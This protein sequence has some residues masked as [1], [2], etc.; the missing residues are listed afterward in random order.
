[1]DIKLVAL[2]LDRTTLNAQGKLS[3]GNRK[4]IEDAINNG[5]HVCIASGRAFDTLPKDVVEVPGIEYAITGN[6]A[7]IYSVKDKKRMHEYLLTP[8][9]V[10]VVLNV[11]KDAPVTY[12]AFIEGVAY[13]SEDYM[14]NPVKYGAT[15]EAVAYVQATRHFKKDIV[16]FIMDNKD[17]LDCMDVIVNDD[18]LKK[19]LME[20]IAAASDEVYLTSSIRQLLEIAHKDAGK[21][22]GVK[23]LA[24]LLGL[25]QGEIA[26]FGDADNDVDMI[27]YAGCGIAMA[28]G[29]ENVL[30]AADKVTLH[31]DEDGVAH[32]FR[33]IINVC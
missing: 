9:S 31:H 11:T 8:E 32:G 26:A 12:E 7:A 27:E 4:A 19:Q 21:M 13:A 17:R 5:V 15:K 23:Y 33:H 16:Q 14:N 6:G 2:D 25:K 28:N 30:K 10:D 18:K 22:S 29:S 24:S 1:M 20:N 3:E